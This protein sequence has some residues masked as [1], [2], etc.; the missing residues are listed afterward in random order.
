M[1]ANWTVLLNDTLRPLN[2]VDFVDTNVGLAVGE[3]GLILKT[4]DGEKT[5]ANKRA[6]PSVTWNQS[7]SLIIIQVG[8]LEKEVQL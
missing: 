3:S 5:G 1:G 7:F 2:S 6:A 8:Q 4:T